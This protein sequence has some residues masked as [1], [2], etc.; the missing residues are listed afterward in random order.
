MTIVSIQP[1]ATP[2]RIRVPGQSCHQNA[3]MTTSGNEKVI[4][5][6]RTRTDPSPPAPTASA[7][8][9]GS[10]T[11]VPSSPRPGCRDQTG[12]LEAGGEAPFTAAVAL[13][14][15]TIITAPC[16]GPSTAPVTLGRERTRRPV[17]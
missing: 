9:I 6:A 17:A 5:G 13:D 7:A 10:T 3:T 16:P 12:A 11:A 14:R 15:T 1:A 8:E 4:I 2:P